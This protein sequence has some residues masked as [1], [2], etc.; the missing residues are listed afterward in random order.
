MHRTK[1]GLWIPD[2]PALLSRRKFLTGA[3]AIAGVS[4]LG[5]GPALAGSSISASPISH[6][7]AQ[8][9]NV[10]TPAI[11]TTGAN[12]IGIWVS[13]VFSA[14]DINDNKS[15]AWTRR[16]QL[17]AID[18]TDG[19]LSYWDCGGAGLVVGS[20]HTFNTAHNTFATIL[21]S[22]WSGVASASYFDNSTQ[23]S[24]TSATS[25]QPGSDTPNNNGSLILVGVQY[26]NTG[27]MCNS[28]LSAIDVVDTTGDVA[29]GGAV[30][31][32]IQGIASAINPAVT[33]TSAAQIGVALVAIKP[34]SY[35]G[36][37]TP[38][39]LFGAIP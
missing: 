34:A 10:T 14:A 7:Y 21:V 24:S 19:E 23:A 36:G 29:V 39:L 11:D 27:L 13:G 37:S 26:G 32:G 2:S 3:A 5:I 20:G 31:Y 12:Y 33:Q 17:S 30:Y 9:N 4:A 18:G 8:G 15:N 16:I 25:Q 1:S 35:S 28:G 22:S 6:T 38:S